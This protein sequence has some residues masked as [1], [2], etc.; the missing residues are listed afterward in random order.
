MMH[1]GVC[2]Y[3]VFVFFAT[4]LEEAVFR[5]ILGI[6]VLQVGRNLSPTLMPC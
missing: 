4:D 5:L 2:M 6:M 1:A 3:Y